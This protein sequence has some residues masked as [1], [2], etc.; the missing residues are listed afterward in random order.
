MNRQLFLFKPRTASIWYV[1]SGQGL[2]C[3]LYQIN[4]SVIPRYLFTQMLTSY[5]LLQWS[6]LFNLSYPFA[7]IL[8]P[9]YLVYFAATQNFECYPHSATA[10]TISSSILT[11]TLIYTDFNQIYWI[12]PFHQQLLTFSTCILISF[13]PHTVTN[14]DL[15][16]YYD[17]H[18]AINILK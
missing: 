10:F 9:V 8:F 14:Q 11:L 1:H 4:V 7:F 17:T 3:S 2:H 16:I 13:L 15:L 6:T 12:L 5:L 18:L